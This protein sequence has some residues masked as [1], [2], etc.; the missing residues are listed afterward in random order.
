M[1]NVTDV[2][3]L[4]WGF[5]WVNDLVP[6]CEMAAGRKADI[7]REAKVKLSWM[8]Y[9][10][11]TGSVS[12]TCRH[13]G[14]TRKTFHKWKKRYDPK[15]LRSLEE[16]D[17]LPQKRRQRELTVEQEARIVALRKKFIR[18]G[19]EKLAKMYQDEYGEKISAWKVQKV[20]E[21]KNI[22][23]NA[24]KT[25]KVTRKRLKGKKKKRTIDLNREQKQD[26]FL[27]LDTIV[28]Y[29]RSMKF[30][31]YTAID[32]TSKVAFARVYKSKA[33][34]NSKDFLTRLLYL[35]GKKIRV[36][37]DNGS[38]F[39]GEFLKACEELNIPQYWSRV[40]TPKDNAVNERFNRTLEEEFLELGN[41]TPD[42][43]ELNR[44]LTEWLIHYNF[45]RPHTTLKY[46]TPISFLVQH[47]KLSPMY[48]SHTHL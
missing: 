8:D 11:K 22:Y 5:G 16:H 21:R 9:F 23:Y 46:L 43:E 39:H 28:L 41:F 1:S 48:S 47:R 15:D 12:K 40:R 34:R 33:S 31:V 36:A 26:L 44:R 30:Y 32:H 35:W 13:F 17:R 4:P 18:L 2:S 3:H 45:E 19:K 14:I 29:F 24:K 6:F 10:Q 20:I 7:S 37:N 25:A 42:I 27:C 38:E